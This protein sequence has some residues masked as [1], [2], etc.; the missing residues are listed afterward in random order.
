MALP[1]SK[2]SSRRNRLPALT[3]QPRRRR[4]SNR[5]SYSFF[6][7]ALALKQTRD[8]KEGALIHRGAFFLRNFLLSFR[9]KPGAC[10]EIVG[11]CEEARRVTRASVGELRA[12]VNVK[13]P[14]GFLFGGSFTFTGTG[15]KP[16]TL[17]TASGVN[18]KLSWRLK[19]A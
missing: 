9:K 11:Y 14:K 19:S 17:S 7:H 2:N 10:E 4:R 13:T 15:A 18:S 1:H 16:A 3:H 6:T 5:G 8:P 12:P